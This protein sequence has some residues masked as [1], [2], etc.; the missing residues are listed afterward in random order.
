MTFRPAL[1]AAAVAMTLGL[2]AC[3]QAPAP[4]TTGAAPPPAGETAD[5]F[6]ARVNKE[7]RS[8]SAEL[9]SAQWLSSTYINSDSE[10]IA[11]KANERWL[12]QLNR[13]IE[14]S[15]RF[16]GQ[17]LSPDTARAIKLLKLMT[18]M[19]APRDPVKLAELTRIATRMEGMYGAGSYCTGEG[20]AKVCRDIGQLSDVL[21]K[22]RD[23]DAQL[24]AWQG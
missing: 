9:N 7:F 13:W 3:K 20:E 21:A 12:T 4:A 8:L 14:Q 10:M 24:D 18:A 6:V 17:Q 19:P 1:L 15:R 2:A 22:S 16:D 5:Q 11:A 23:Y